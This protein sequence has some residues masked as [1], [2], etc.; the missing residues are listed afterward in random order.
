VSRNWSFMWRRQLVVDEC[1]QLDLAVGALEEAARGTATARTRFSACDRPRRLHLDAPRSGSTKPTHCCTGCREAVLW[2]TAVPVGDLPGLHGAGERLGPG[3]VQVA[4]PA[5]PM[6]TLTRRSGRGRGGRRGGERGAGGQC[7]RDR[8]DANCHRFPSR[9]GGCPGVC[10]Q[11][12]RYAENDAFS[13][14]VRKAHLSGVTER[15]AGANG[16]WSDSGW[17]LGSRRTGGTRRVTENSFQHRQRSGRDRRGR[18]L[19]PA[20][21]T[22]AAQRAPAARREVERIWRHGGTRRA[23]AAHRHRTARWWNGCCGSSR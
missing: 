13:A 8:G 22:G 21:G 14:Q 20:L 5:R 2:P 6:I 9:N 17:R 4:G 11:R 15:L 3:R 12:P 23:G 18:G 7:H 1:C 16:R 19:R 10:A